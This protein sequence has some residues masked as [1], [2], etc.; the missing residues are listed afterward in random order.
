MWIEKSKVIFLHLVLIILSICVFWKWS[1]LAVNGLEE[2]ENCI[3]INFGKNLKCCK[4]SQ[5]QCYHLYSKIS[6]SRRTLGPNKNNWMKIVCV[7][8]SV[9]SRVHYFQYSGIF[10]VGQMLQ[11]WN[12]QHIT[13]TN[14]QTQCYYPQLLLFGVKMA[15]KCK[16]NTVNPFS[17]WMMTPCLLMGRT[18]DLP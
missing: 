14:F 3:F 1:M 18:T 10:Q 13:N 2:N 5:Q 6:I 11:N 9:W 12:R 4:S 7:T 15:L 16:G 8:V 17:R